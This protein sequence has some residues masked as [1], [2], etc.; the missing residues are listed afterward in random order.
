MWCSMFPFSTYETQVNFSA[1]HFVEI[2]WNMGHWW[3]G[4][5]L[6][7]VSLFLPGCVGV[8]ILSPYAY[9]SLPG[10]SLRSS[11][12]PTWVHVVALRE[13]SL[14]LSRFIVYPVFVLF[15]LALDQEAETKTRCTLCYIAPSKLKWQNGGN[16]TLIQ[17]SVNC[18]E[19]PSRRACGEEGRMQGDRHPG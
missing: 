5:I 17:C 15:C 14:E 10:S 9:P 13:C 7:L 18:W 2:Y 16:F 4:G 8:P 19:I 12:G 3:R 1:Q 6:S 11:S